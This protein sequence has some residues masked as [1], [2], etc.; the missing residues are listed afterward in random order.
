MRSVQK[1]MFTPHISRCNQ[2]GEAGQLSEIQKGI[3]NVSLSPFK[4]G[5]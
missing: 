1:R 4:K 3:Y 2:L 5:A